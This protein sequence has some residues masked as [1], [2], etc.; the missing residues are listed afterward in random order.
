MTAERAV[1]SLEHGAVWLTYNRP[2]G[3]TSPA[4]PNRQKGK[5]YVLLSPDKDLTAPVTATADT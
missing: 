2:W 4:S 3:R 5:P 1:H